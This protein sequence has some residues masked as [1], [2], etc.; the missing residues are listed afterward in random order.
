MKK[1]FNRL[2]QEKDLRYDLFIGIWS[3]IIILAIL[4]AIGLCIYFLAVKGGSIM[5]NKTAQ[6]T[7]EPTAQPQESVSPVLSAT[8]E[9]TERPSYENIDEEDGEDDEDTVTVYA[10]TTVNV[11]SKPNTSAASY[12][13]LSAGESVKRTEKM[14][15]GWSKVIYDDK[16]AYIK[17]DYL[18]TTKPE[19]ATKSP[20]NAPRVTSRPK[21][22]KKPATSKP[23]TKKP[24]AT[25]KANSNNQSDN[26]AV[27]IITPS[28]EP[29]YTKA[30][31]ITSA[32]ADTEAPGSAT[33][34]PRSDSAAVQTET[35]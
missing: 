1:F 30:P 17:S 24:T 31:Q 29:D 33:E 5:Q 23:S 2:K 19:T 3:A 8:E 35:P 27:E 13:K 25:H 18:S 10:I 22:T 34:A 32:P 14:S 16:T 15:N 7:E 6:A 28:P 11:R 9:P 4:A 26:E 12:G 20:T 21:T